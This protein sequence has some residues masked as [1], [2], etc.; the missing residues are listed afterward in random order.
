MTGMGIIGHKPAVL[1]EPDRKDPY[2]FS[3]MRPK[4]EGTV[5]PISREQQKSLE[6]TMSPLPLETGYAT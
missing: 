1:P 6:P 5:F 2:A 4:P 3:A